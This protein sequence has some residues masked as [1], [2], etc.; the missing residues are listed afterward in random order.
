MSVNKTM[1]A[2]FATCCSAA[3]LFVAMPLAVADQAP[4][5]GDTA[6]ITNTTA[7]VTATPT[8]VDENY[9]IQEEDILR[10]DVWG[11]PQLTNMQMQV[12]PDG[13]LN[14]AYLGTIQ[15]AG[16]TVQQLT[17]TI[18]KGFED[19]GI[20]YNAKVQITVITLHQPIVR[21]L[22]EVQKPGAVVFKDGDT[23]YDAIAQAGSYTQNAWLAKATITHK[24]DEKPIPIDLKK[25]FDGDLSQNMKLQKGDT[26]YIPPE[27][28]QN[29]IY[30]MGQVMRPNIYSLKDNTTVLAAVNLAG[31]PTERGVLRSTMVIRGNPAKPEK[32]PCNLTKLLDK[33]DLS[34]DIVLH[35]GDVV[36]VPETKS[37]N[38]NK[39]SQV[40]STIMNLTYIRRY[41]IF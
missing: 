3:L 38:W 23:I 24:G 2:L 32:V 9:K 36:Y 27:D 14:M 17:N 34:Q 40:L 21:V 16:L 33:A 19:A 25:M 18:I 31:G 13:K 11:E 22:G 6:S 1:L 20:L 37:P 5:A 35:P 15:A 8:S 7:T 10:M 39:I 12:T 41:G 29:K 4:A 26:I 28:Y 30:V